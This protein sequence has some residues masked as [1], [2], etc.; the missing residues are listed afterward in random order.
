MF[1]WRLGAAQA[2]RQ[3]R[4]LR[5]KPVPLEG[6][7]TVVALGGSRSAFRLSRRL[8]EWLPGY[9]PR[10]L[11]SLILSEVGKVVEVSRE[12]L[13]RDAV[14][15]IGRDASA[16]L[17]VVLDQRVDDAHVLLCGSSVAGEIFDIGELGMSIRLVRVESRRLSGLR[18]II[19]ELR[20][21]QLG[22]RIVEEVRMARRL[23]RSRREIV[24]VR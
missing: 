17:T 14:R 20:V 13:D 1:D 16:C 4:W 11:L 12:R 10:L 23:K 9:R 24:A 2:F 7:A 21:L 3:L 18:P 22:C 5:R 8:L 15:R 19:D 6:V